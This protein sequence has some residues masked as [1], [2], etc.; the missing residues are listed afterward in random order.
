MELEAILAS[1]KVEQAELEQAQVMA[2]ELEKTQSQFNMI[3]L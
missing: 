3:I 2:K 1:F